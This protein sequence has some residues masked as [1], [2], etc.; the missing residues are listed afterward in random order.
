M[1]P[2]LNVLHVHP[3]LI[4]KYLL[5]MPLVQLER[6]G[7]VQSMIV[8]PAILLVQFVLVQAILSVMPVIQVTFCSQHPQKQHV[9][10]LVPQLDIG[11]TLQTTF[12]HLALSP[13]QFALMAPTL[14]VLPAQ[15]GTFYNHCLQHVLTL[16]QMDIG[17]TL[18]LTV[19]LLAI[20]LAQF[21]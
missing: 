14:H 8:A 6:A 21:V 15:P 12:V 5:V 16:V 10:A 1:E 2:T 19:V 20:L 13:V 18:Q 11:R 9:L 4:F 17:E 3:L 7:T